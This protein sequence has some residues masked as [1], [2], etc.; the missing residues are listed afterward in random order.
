MMTRFGFLQNF[1]NVSS[2]RDTFW[3]CGMTGGERAAVNVL[4]I[5][6]ILSSYRAGKSYAGIDNGF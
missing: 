1:S 3:R 2:F 5:H 4:D 6:G